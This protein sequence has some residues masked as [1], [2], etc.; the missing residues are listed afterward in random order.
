MKPRGG[1]RV[2]EMGIWMARGWRRRL[3]PIGI[4]TA[5]FGYGLAQMMTWA[6]A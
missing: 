1:W 3:I 2:K 4:F 6:N 5:R